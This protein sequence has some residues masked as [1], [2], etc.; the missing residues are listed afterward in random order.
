MSQT[1]IVWHTSAELDPAGLT[2][3][4]SALRSNRRMKH[5]SFELAE[6]DEVDVDGAV[7]ISNNRIDRLI[8]PGEV[9]AIIEACLS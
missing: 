3:I 8:D 5:A 9:A 1:R 7:T 6:P 2:L 4:R